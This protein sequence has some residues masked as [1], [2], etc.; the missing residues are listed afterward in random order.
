MTVND[1]NA[2]PR[3][4]TGLRV[5]AVHAHPDD[6]TI[7][8]G[9]TLHQ[10][11]ARGADCTVVTCTLGEEGEVIGP[12]WQNLIADEADQLG[13]YRIAELSAAL[14]A[15]GVHGEFLGGAGAYRDSG[16]AGTPSAANPRAFVN[17]GGRAVDDL[18]E[19]LERLRPQLV[20]TYDPNGGYGHPDHIHA[21]EITH[22]A[23]ERV[24]VDRLLWHVTPT[25]AQDAGLAAIAEIPAGWRRAADGELAAVADDQVD[26]V[27]ELSDADVAAKLAGFRAH[28]TQLHV[29]DGSV[30]RTNPVAAEASVS[31]HD[32]VAAVY[33][34]SNLI[35]QPVLRREYFHLAAG[36]PVPAGG[37]PADGLLP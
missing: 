25:G 22:A 8:M 13:G 16:M 9:G 12:T 23:L 4:L 3:D 32:T 2:N 33:C 1:P 17:D 29:A 37:G 24:E 28:A 26:C 27:S 6:E 7:T 36:T 20:L 30:S 21:H 5:V 18:V 10:L 14:A 31:D 35:A 34:L 19:V 11:A 15:V